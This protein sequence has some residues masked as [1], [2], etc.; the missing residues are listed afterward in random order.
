MKY[1]VLTTKTLENEPYEEASNGTIDFDK[2]LQEKYEEQDAKLA[3]LGYKMQFEE[4]K[5]HFFESHFHHDYTTYDDIDSAIQC[6]AI[7][8][9]A[10]LVRWENGNI[11][12]IATYNEHMNGFEIINE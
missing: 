5:I 7:K 8:E 3:E 2:W 12:F 11:G 1:T 6:L 9:G 4:Y 10:D